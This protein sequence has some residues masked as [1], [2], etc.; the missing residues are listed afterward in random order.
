LFSAQS[1]LMMEYLIANDKLSN[2]GTYFGLVETDKVPID[3]AIQKAFGLTADQLGKAVED[4]FQSL[5][6]MLQSLNNPHVKQVPMP[7]PVAADQVGSSVHDVPLPTAQALVAE[8]ALRVPEHREQARQELESLITGEKT[9]TVIDH[10]ALGWYYLNKKDFEKTNDELTK[11]LALDGKDSWTHFYL[12]L[13]KERQAKAS[14]HATQGLANMIQDLHAVLDW[15]PEFAQAYAMLAKAQL[16]GGGVHSA[17]D[18]IRAATKLSPRNQDYLLEMAQVYSA[19]KNWEAA[20]AMLQMLSASSD[21]HIAGAA[22]EQLDALPYLKKYGVAPQQAAAQTPPK[23]GSSPA[24]PPA[25]PPSPQKTSSA[26]PQPAQES[27]EE[28]A[29]EAP[30]EPQIDRRP[31]Q[32]L[33]GKLVSVDCSQPPVALITISTGAKNMKLRAADYKSLTLI[34]ADNFSCDWKNQNVSVNYKPGG[35]ADGDLVSLEIK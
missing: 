32:Y 33:K 1:W 31:I 26:T 25:S 18:S 9:E 19:G 6:E 12:A 24:S 16:E 34:G 10:R 7:A 8:M 28:K 15:Y 35:K 14:S 17:T 22:R 20:N 21:P 11:A 13:Y 3:D 4:Y 5:L 27:D 29:E 30:A 2:A 23:P